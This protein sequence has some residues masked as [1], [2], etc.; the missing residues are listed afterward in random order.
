MWTVYQVIIDNSNP[1]RIIGLVGWQDATLLPFG[2][3]A[4][5]IQFI[6]VINRQRVDCERALLTK[7]PN[8]HRCL[9]GRAPAKGVTA[10]AVKKCVD[11][12]GRIDIVICGWIL[13]APIY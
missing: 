13:L 2:M 3:N 11:Q 7:A 9:C 4:Y 1:L 10:D 12:F 6:V 8:L 5:Q